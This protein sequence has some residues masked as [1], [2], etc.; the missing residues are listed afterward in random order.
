LVSNPGSEQTVTSTVGEKLAV[1]EDHY[2]FGCGRENPHGLKLT[3]F[4]AEDGGVW[5]DWTP[6]RV[7]EGYNGIAHGGII[8][9]VLDEVM[10]WAVSHRKIWAV[11]GKIGVNF[12]KPV[13]IGEPTRAAARVVTELGRR[14]QVTADLRRASD[15]ILLADAEA[16]FI[17]VPEERAKDWQ[18]RYIDPA[19]WGESPR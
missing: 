18:A 8:S 5:S 11:T 3:F 13:T 10:G 14:I 7:N 15:G 6:T 19:A 4:S 1:R 2:C 17:R 9:T 12:R 16:I